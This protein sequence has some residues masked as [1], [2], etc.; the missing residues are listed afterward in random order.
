MGW[1]AGDVM[2]RKRDLC[3]LLLPPCVHAAT[4]KGA[5]WTYAA[6]FRAGIVHRAP[7][8]GDEGR[9]TACNSRQAPWR[10]TVTGR[11]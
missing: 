11:G 5:Q 2:Q 6:L 7:Y 10:A 4:R 9:F 1:L 3:S 8:T